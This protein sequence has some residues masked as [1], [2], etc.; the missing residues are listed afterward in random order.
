MAKMDEGQ[1]VVLNW[2]LS[3][4]KNNQDGQR[5][6]IFHTRCTITG[7]VYL[8]ISD[9]ESCTNVASSSML[10]KIKL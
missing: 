2:T 5:E 4:L 3:S 10:E 8:L 1:L 6:K 9:S 7:K